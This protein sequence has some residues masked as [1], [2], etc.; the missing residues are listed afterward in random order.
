M[1]TKKTISELFS[2]LLVHEYLTNSALKFPDKTALVFEEKRYTYKDLDYLSDLLAIKLI[3]QGVKRQDRI[4]IWGENSHEVVLSIYATLKAGATFI[5]LNS[6]IKPPKFNYI[7]KDS[8]PTIIIADSKLKDSVEI[9]LQHYNKS[10]LVFYLGDSSEKI[11]SLLSEGLKTDPSPEDFQLL[12]ERKKSILDYDLAA[13]IYT[14]GSTGEPKGVMSSHFNIVSA[15]KSIITYLNNTDEDIIIDVLPL[16]FDYGLYQVIMCFMYGGTIILEKS[17]LFPV[18]ILK[19]IENEKVTGFPI[20]PT[21]LAMLLKLDKIKEYNLKTL[22]YISNTGAALP[23][24]HIKKFRNLFPEIKIFS[25]FGLTECKRIAY[26]PPE[27]IDRKPGS[28]GK[29]MPNCEVFIVDENGKEVKPNIVGELV[30]RGSNVMRGYW[31]SEELTNQVFRKGWM[32]QE[33]V[34]FTGDY[35]YKDE[36]GYLYFVGR[37]DDMIKTKGER[38][39]P[40]ELENILCSIE[41]VSEAAVIGVPDEIFGQAIKAFIVKKLNSQISE[42]DILKYCKENVELFMIPKIIVFIESLPKNP[43]GK[44][45]K[46]KLKEI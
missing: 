28:V 38:V 3:K 36:E 44:V 19:K 39:S 2:P 34:L 45:D 12:T 15:A 40:K 1:R 41:G 4:I 33:R 24:E 35:F 17:F 7:L 31:N 21:I 11:N 30:V 25:M 10:V 8:E 43:N 27:D 6:L 20:V 14:S 22:R 42:N 18:E 9:A 37:K 46:K 5:V 32:Q 13:L 26:L 23:V 29:A 16:S